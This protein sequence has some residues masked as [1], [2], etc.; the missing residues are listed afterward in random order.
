LLVVVLELLAVVVLV[1]VV[2]PVPDEVV[3]TAP[4]PDDEPVWPPLPVVELS[5]WT[6][7]LPH[8]TTATG[9]PTMSRDEDR[10]MRFFLGRK[11]P[12]S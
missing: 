7:V 3:V 8:A 2:A 12:R 11:V 10:R 6:T 4:A 1:V 5:F 9:K